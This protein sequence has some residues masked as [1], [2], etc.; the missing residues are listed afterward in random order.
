MATVAIDVRHLGDF[1]YGT[2]IRN[3][4]RAMAE[5]ERELQFVLIARPGGAGELGS[6]PDNFRMVEYAREDSARVEDIAFPWFVRKLGVDLVHLPLNRV[7]V[8]MPRPYVVTIHD[9]SS[10]VYGYGDD[11]PD[12]LHLWKFRRGLLRASRVIAVSGATRRDVLNLMNLS[13]DHVRQIYNALDPGFLAIETD[14]RKRQEVVDRYQIGYPYLL[15]AGSVNPRK[16]VARIV[17]AFALLRQDLTDHPRYKDLRLVII[18]DQISKYPALRRAVHQSRVND[19]V[20]FLGFVRRE[21]LKV[22]YQGAEA[23]V[24]PS[25]YEGFGL[26]PLEAMAL[27]TPVVTSGVSALPEVVGDAAMIVKPE[28]VFDIA[29]GMREVLLD[30]RLRAD[31]IARGHQQVKRFSWYDTA[32]QVLETY[33]DAMGR[34]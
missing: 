8:F 31:L 33:R 20:R 1:G 6:L 18:G 13:P 26:P 11:T 19:V 17:E 3:L 15:Y 10:L 7:P 14:A 22:F 24:F 21:E 30:D 16:N 2:Y 27:G 29:R 32:R 9:M 28:N 34:A 5:L 23:F 25:L 4:V 12:R